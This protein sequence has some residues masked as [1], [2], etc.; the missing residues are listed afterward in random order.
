MG[1]GEYDYFDENKK[2][3][4][5][6]FSDIHVDSTIQTFASGKILPTD[7]FTLSPVYKFQGNAELFASRKFLTFKGGVKMEFDCEKIKNDFAYFETEINPDTI[8]IPIKS[9]LLNLSRRDL[10]AASFITKDSSHIYSSFLTRRRDPNDE[11][12]VRAS[13]YLFYNKNS[14]KYI[15]AE[16][17]KINNPDTTGSLVSLNKDYCIY[18][19]E[20]LINP[21]IELGQIKMSPAGSF[22]HDLGKNEIKLDLIL[23]IDFFFSNAALDT[24]INDLKTQKLDAFNITSPFFEKNMIERYGEANNTE[25][26]NQNMLFADE[27]KL[28]KDIQHT[29][30]IGSIKLKWHTELGSYLSYGKI[31][32]STINNKPINKYVDGYFQLIKRRSGDLLKF[33]I[34]LPNNN[35][36]YFTYSRGVMQSLSNNKK[37]VDAINAIKNKNRKLSTPRNETPYRYIIATEQNLQQFLREIHLFE[38]SQASGK[39]NN[40]V[41]EPEIKNNEE[42]TDSINTQNELNIEDDGSDTN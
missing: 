26:K 5:I 13:G 10:Y 21:G 15:V 11:T 38:E 40:K 17:S 8:Y 33:Y 29:I 7:T 20:G 42:P 6:H 34:K 16:K 22:N 37:F 32:I 24:L 3:Q 25:F 12:L 19:G 35:Y 41:I 30:L 31:G 36:Y 1:S 2:K 39:E 28:P 4:T 27:A 23:P 18:H 14:K 9:D